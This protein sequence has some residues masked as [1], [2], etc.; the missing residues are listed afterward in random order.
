VTGALAGGT[1][2]VVVFLVWQSR[3]RT[4]MLPLRLFRSRAFSAGNAV[5]FLLSG[6]MSA[7]VFFIAQYQQVTL[8]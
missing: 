2:L 3:A 4:P 8:G 1:V 6:S 5:M 7:S